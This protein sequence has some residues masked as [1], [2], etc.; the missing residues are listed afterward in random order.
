MLCTVFESGMKDIRMVWNYVVS[1]VS[2][3]LRF[4]CGWEGLPFVSDG[5]CVLKDNFQ[6]LRGEG[7]I[8]QKAVSLGK[9]KNAIFGVGHV[10]IFAGTHQV[11]NKI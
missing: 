3:K 6:P 1:C 7:E 9:T 2:P 8:S 10:P 4:V 11:V 5:D